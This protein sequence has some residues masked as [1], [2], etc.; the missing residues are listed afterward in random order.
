MSLHFTS[1]ACVYA[2]R[3]LVTKAKMRHERE[4]STKLESRTRICTAP[5][6]S[7][8]ITTKPDQTSCPPIAPGP[9]DPTTLQ[10][11]PSERPQGKPPDGSLPPRRRPDRNGR[12]W[13]RLSECICMPEALPEHAGKNK[14]KM[15]RQI[16]EDLHLPLEISP[17]LRLPDLHC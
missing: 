13:L 8:A 12:G 14:R 9:M 11:T 15:W 7:K 5:D 2:A 17:S 4:V 3:I 6:I 10:S 1:E 16:Q